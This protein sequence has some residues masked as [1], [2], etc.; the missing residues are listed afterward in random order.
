M[1]DSAERKL[2]LDQYLE[3]EVEHLSAFVV[4]NAVEKQDSVFF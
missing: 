3:K 4:L 1:K 2:S